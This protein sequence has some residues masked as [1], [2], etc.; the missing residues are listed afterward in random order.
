[1]EHVMILCDHSPISKFVY[2]VMKNDKVYNWSQEIHTIMPDTEM[3]LIKGKENILADS[4]SRLKTL[5][6]YKT[7]TPQKEE[8]VYGKSIF[9]PET[10]CST[11]NSQKVNQDFEVD[12]TKILT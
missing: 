9:D 3:E 10:E 6:L 12:G 5:G 8:H 4:L 11:D 2:S 1:M 7:S